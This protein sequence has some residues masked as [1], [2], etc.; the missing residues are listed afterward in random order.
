MKEISVSELQQWKEEGKDFQ[1]IDVREPFEYEMSNIQGENIPLAG[2]VI[3]ADKISKEKPVVMQCRSGARSAAAI[4][5]L[6][7]NLGYSNLYNLKGGILAWA[8]E[9][10]DS[11]QVY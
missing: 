6:E 2:V 4:N 11:I 7:Q 1:L 5:Q 8:A 9:I 3:E 10:D